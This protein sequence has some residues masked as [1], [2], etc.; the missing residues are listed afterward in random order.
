MGSLLISSM[1]GSISIYWLAN[2]NNYR[3]TKDEIEQL[4]HALR[5]PRR[6]IAANGIVEDNFT[7]LCMVLARLA[8]PVRL[9]ELQMMFGW[10]PERVSQIINCTME[11]IHNTWKHLLEFDHVRMTPYKLEEYA[12]AIRQQNAPLDNC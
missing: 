9:S 7:A 5:L 10:K 1:L 6:I 12:S 8:Y 11:I 4:V 3:F 2:R